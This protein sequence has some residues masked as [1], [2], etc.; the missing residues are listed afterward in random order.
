MGAA[1]A[2]AKIFGRQACHFGDKHRLES[3]K[4]ELSE[5]NMSIVHFDSFLHQ[6]AIICNCTEVSG[7]VN[8][9]LEE[10]MEA[11]A[12]PNID[13]VGVYG[14]STLRT[15]NLI[16]KMSRR[17]K[18]DNLFDV[19]VIASVTKK[20]DLKRIQGELGKMLGLQFGEET[21]VGR[22]KLLCDR[23]KK[24]KR[25]LIILND[26]YAGL[27]LDR[28]GIPFGVHHKGCKIVLLS[29]SADVLINQIKHCN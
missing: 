19:T 22:A 23:I 9:A 18:R 26:L 8:M 4:K 5:S 7:L 1:L 27:N 28:V 10:A 2:T 14:S 29:G 6:K 11:L 3:Q 24:E 13:M 15:N 12:N 25:I 16:E 20:P 21:V 17:V